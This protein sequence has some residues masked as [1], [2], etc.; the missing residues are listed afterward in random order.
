MLSHASSGNRLINMLQAE[1]LGPLLLHKSTNKQEL[2]LG[3]GFLQV[4]VIHMPW[5]QGT[6]KPPG[7]RYA[8]QIRLFS[9]ST[10]LSGAACAR[11]FVS[12]VLLGHR[13]CMCFG[14]SRRIRAERTVHS[15]WSGDC[16]ATHHAQPDNLV[17]LQLK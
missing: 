14:T 16:R 1:L 10:M 9:S 7:C 15:T 6:T 11:S 12:P 2:W 5:D 8:C 3:I 13:N 17:N 4:P